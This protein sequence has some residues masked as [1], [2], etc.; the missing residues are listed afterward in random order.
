MFN[1]ESSIHLHEIEFSRKSIHNKLHCSSIV[2][3]NCLCCRHSSFTNMR[4][5]LSCHIWSWSLLNNLLMPSLQTAV[6]LIK[7]DYVSMLVAKHL[8]LYMS[9]L[10]NVLLNQ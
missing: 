2:V 10:S 9:G 1:L 7:V 5:K 4:P 6:S 3:T 8:D